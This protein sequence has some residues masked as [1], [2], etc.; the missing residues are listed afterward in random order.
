L[1]HGFLSSKWHTVM[2]PIFTPH[3]PHILRRC[4]LVLA[5]PPGAVTKLALGAA[6]LNGLQRA[7]LTAEQVD[8]GAKFG[9]GH[10]ACL[11]KSACELLGCVLVL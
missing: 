9:L 10:A 6:G 4:G 8:L 3:R 5:A 11:N 1:C 2:T 7:Q